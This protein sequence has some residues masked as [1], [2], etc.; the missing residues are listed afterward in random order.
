VFLSPLPSFS[1]STYCL[2]CCRRGRAP[3]G[4]ASWQSQ[5]AL[6]AGC[7]APCW[8]RAGDSGRTAARAGLWFCCATGWALRRKTNNAFKA[9][10]FAKY[11]WDIWTV[12]YASRKNAGLKNSYRWFLGIWWPG[13]VQ[14]FWYRW[15][16]G[17]TSVGRCCASSDTLRPG[18]AWVGSRTG[19]QSHE[20]ENNYLE[21][22]QQY[23]WTSLLPLFDFELF[24][25]QV[26]QN[27]IKMETQELL[28]KKII[29]QVNHI[30]IICV[31]N[32][33]AFI[34]T[35]DDFLY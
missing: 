17:H 3:Q 11:I 7:C 10:F 12:K 23:F 13:W 25:C 15:K 35:H 32:I 30:F 34:S 5:M 21:Q 8:E 14:F 27:L 24:F 22:K 1:R 4:R 26:S 2:S 31:V 29:L 20:K 9:T 28:S 16:K 33:Q 6:W 19:L 18:F